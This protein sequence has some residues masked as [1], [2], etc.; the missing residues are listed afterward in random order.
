MDVTQRAIIVVI[1]IYLFI[2]IFI[3]AY[4]NSVVKMEFVDFID[5]LVLAFI[6][7]IYAEYSSTKN[8]SP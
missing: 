6:G 1:I 8:K 4:F 7:G 2:R 5:Y 3:L